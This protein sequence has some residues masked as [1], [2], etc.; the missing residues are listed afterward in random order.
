MAVS[1]AAVACSDGAQT[2]LPPRPTLLSVTMAD[3]GFAHR[4][5]ANPGR[6][7][8]E[9]R[10]DDTVAHQLVIVRLP[11]DMVGTLADQLRS[12]TR[13]PAQTLQQSGFAPG[14]RRAFAVDLPAGHYGFVCFVTDP[15][16]E[17]HARKGMASDLW[18]G[19]PPRAPG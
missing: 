16:G 7:I 10:N 4:P 8:V 18:V 2:T 14:E 6:V 13:R 11:D 1:L 12:E 17:S 19:P 15:D 9:A 5:G 3:L